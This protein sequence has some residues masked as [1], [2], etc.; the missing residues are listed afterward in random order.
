VL[1]APGQAIFKGSH[2]SKTTNLHRWE[3]YQRNQ[4]GEF[5]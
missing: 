5:Q 4:S 2:L 3:I 1:S